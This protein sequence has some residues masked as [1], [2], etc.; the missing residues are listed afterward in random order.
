MP[1]LIQAAHGLRGE[2]GLK[3]ALEAVSFEQ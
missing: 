3:E 1:W 2:E